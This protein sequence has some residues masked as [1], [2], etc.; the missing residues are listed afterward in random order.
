M[1]S[2]DGEKKKEVF[3]FDEN[4]ILYA[5]ASAEYQTRREGDI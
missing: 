2:L 3:W 4:Q 5:A 1:A